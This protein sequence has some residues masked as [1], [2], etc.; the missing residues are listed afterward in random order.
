MRHNAGNMGLD[1]TQSPAGAGSYRFIVGARPSGR[2][3]L[4]VGNGDVETA[5]GSAGHGIALTDQGHAYQQ[6]TAAN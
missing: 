1:P 4:L 2:F 5:V 3:V 6:R